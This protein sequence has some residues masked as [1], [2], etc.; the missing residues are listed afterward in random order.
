LL[1]EDDPQAF[2]QAVIRLLDR[3]EERS[4]LGGAAQKQ[5]AGYDWRVVIPKF[6]DV[7]RDLFNRNDQPDKCLIQPDEFND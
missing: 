3:P 1:I 6:N 5:A 7:Y 2:A 4:R